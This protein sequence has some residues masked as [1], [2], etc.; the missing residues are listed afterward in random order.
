LGHR[1]PELIEPDVQ[2]TLLFFKLVAFFGVEPDI[3]VDAEEITS[4]IFT[5]AVGKNTHKSK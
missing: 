1:V 5:T 4:V 3:V 2:M